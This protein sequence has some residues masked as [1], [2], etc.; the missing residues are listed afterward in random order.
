MVGLIFIKTSLSKKNI[1]SENKAPIDSTCAVLADILSENRYFLS[2]ISGQSSLVWIYFL[3][4][5][6]DVL[7][8]SNATLL[9]VL[10]P[11]N[12]IKG[13]AVIHA[14]GAHLALNSVQTF[15][16]SNDPLAIKLCETQTDFDKKMI[17]NAEMIIWKYLIGRIL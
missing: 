9:F 11:Y 16:S 6:T 2:L 15:S 8:I 13:D 4:F 14:S 7:N 5:G 1:E 3:V 10:P 12:G 17:N